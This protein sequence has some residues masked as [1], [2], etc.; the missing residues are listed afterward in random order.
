MKVNRELLALG[1]LVLLLLA[2]GVFFYGS[3]DS[4]FSREKE[5]LVNFTKALG[6]AKKVCLVMDVSGLQEPYRKNVFSCG[7]DFS[8]SLG[9]LGK[10]VVVYAFENGTCTKKDAQLPEFF[11]VVEMKSLSC[12]IIYISSGRGQSES[13]RNLLY[14]DV[15][16]EYKQG[17]CSVSSP[18]ISTPA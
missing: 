11:C 3:K 1:V 16:R 15:P 8:Y 18:S 6:N 14:V 4:L 13:Y 5:P 17:E 12:P 7:V 2:Y 10:D 9:L